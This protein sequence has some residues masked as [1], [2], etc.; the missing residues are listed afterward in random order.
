[1]RNSFTFRLILLLSM[2]SAL[3]I[4]AAMTIDY[5]LA[6][7]EIL[8]RL[9]E[10]SLVT[11]RNSISDLEN[12]LDGVESSAHFMANFLGRQDLTEEQ[13]ENLLRDIVETNVDVFG[14]A[15]ALNPEL[16]SDEAGF[17]PYYHKAGGLIQ[18]KNL[19]DGPE[20][21]WS[22][23][24]YTQPIAA[25]KPVW[26]EPYFDELGA[27]VLMTTYSIPVYRED[28]NGAPELFG[29]V[30]ADV[31]LEELKAYISRL[32]LGDNGYAFLVSGEG[33]ILASKADSSAM[34]NY[35]DLIYTSPEAS[36]WER[37]I[38]GSDQLEDKP[39]LV[40]C[41][42]IDDKCA[43]R[44]SR[45]RT[46]DWPFGVVY[47]EDELLAPLR[48]FT[49]K[50][51]I[52]ST[53][54]LIIMVLSGT[55]IVRR[56]TSPLT[57]LAIAVDAIGGGELR[58]PLPRAKG[59][60]EVAR[61]IRSF[62]SMQ[63]DLRSYI[64]SLEE[65]TAARSRLEGELTAAREI[66][67]AMLPQGGEAIEKAEAFNLWAKVRPA[68]TVGGDLYSYYRDEQRLYLIVGDVSDKGVPAALFMA[69]AMSL[70][71]QQRANLIQPEAGMSL[72]NDALEQDN[73]NCMF[74][75]LFL[76]VLDLQSYALTFASAGHTPP[77]L[78]RNGVANT[79]EQ[80]AGPALA[81]ASGLQFS[82]N[83]LQLQAGDRLAIYTDG[84]DEAFNIDAEMFGMERF[85]QRLAAGVDEA[86]E[87]AGIGIIDS[88]DS[89]AAGT[90]QSDDITL[91]L[92]DIPEAKA[93]V[94]SS[95][96]QL[97]RS[98]KLDAQL[99]ASSGEWLEHA[100]EQT[101]VAP[102]IIMEMTLVLEELVTNVRKYAG[103]PEDAEL[104]VQVATTGNSLILTIVDGGVA[105]NPLEDAHRS[106]LGADI[107]SAEI[108][109]LGVHLV[110]QLTDEQVYRREGDQ[111]LLRVV[112]LLQHD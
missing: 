59:H 105:F 40:Q 4:A 31:T 13:L 16:T 100:L 44:T 49:A 19:A 92:L 101:G 54:I 6:R 23:H 18:R 71:Q 61:L 73:E 111:N 50:S 86:V 65:V 57:K 41:P 77:S 53:I 87:D 112:K 10:E 51:T 24:W 14:A 91:M 93:A 108:G 29:V 106:P 109:G 33:A 55:L 83:T 99:N 64:S 56:L 39:Q 36:S 94:S 60:D 102:D 21:Y 95:T 58:A 1:M 3:I 74:V 30:T 67:M 17:A 68:K 48:E 70:L 47:S 110:T 45:L 34:R 32:R 26:V 28:T 103:L 15:I 107:E 2:S 98:F 89:F 96:D 72:L 75:T 43:I 20:N 84:I 66:Q 104:T 78:L 27:E 42:H 12:M 11:V 76:G 80:D 22:Q 9:R 97:S 63:T 52:L 82:A 88:V 85:N 69:R 35:R 46:T 81:L 37:A 79:I 62:A 7:D 5:R 38:S 25:G 8:D 90:A